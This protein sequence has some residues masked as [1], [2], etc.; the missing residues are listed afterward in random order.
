MT[1]LR[2]FDDR[3]ALKEAGRAL[4]NERNAHAQ[5][6]AE[7]ERV[8]LRAQAAERELEA[9]RRLVAEL[10]ARLA[11][12]PPST[13]E[14]TRELLEWRA[15]WYTEGCPGLGVPY[16]VADLA[17]DAGADL[18]AALRMIGRPSTTDQIA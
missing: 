5:T 2:Q 9:E 14:P 15:R 12:P 11:P 6:R 1:T 7:L 18:A 3:S 16:T 17:A 4:E 8:R 10:K 13:P